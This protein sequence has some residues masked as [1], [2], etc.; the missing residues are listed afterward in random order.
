MQRS[1]VLVLLSA[2]SGRGHTVRAVSSSTNCILPSRVRRDSSRAH[3]SRILFDCASHSNVTFRA[4]NSQPLHHQ[5]F[6]GLTPF[7]DPCAK[8]FI[9]WT[10]S[11]FSD[12][13]SAIDPPGLC[14][15]ASPAGRAPGA[16][17]WQKKNCPNRLTVGATLSIPQTPFQGSR[18]FVMDD[19]GRPP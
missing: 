15:P 16:P 14:S 9:L 7:P 10:P 2:G 6:L 13:A 11:I 12:G 17:I 18:R 4:I 19:S 8:G 1:P 5:P 3:G